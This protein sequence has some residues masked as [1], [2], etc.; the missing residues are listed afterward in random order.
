[1]KKQLCLVLALIVSVS[2]YGQY[3]LVGGKVV[4]KNSRDWTVFREQIEV[5]GFS[6]QGLRCRTFAEQDVT[7]GTI[8]LPGSRGPHP[9]TIPNI[10]RSRT[11]GETFV[12]INYPGSG[13]FRAGDTIRTPI[14]AMR[15]SSPVVNSGADRIVSQGYS[16]YDYGVDYV[17]PQRQLT[18]EETA[19]AAVQAVK[20]NSNKVAAKLKF[21]EEQ[22]DNGKAL[23]QYRMG[24]RYLKGDGVT[25]DLA[26]AEE[27]F[28]KSAAQGNEDAAA[29]LR[30]LSEP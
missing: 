7:V 8:V 28:F 25:N 21:E 10:Q 19:A 12:L 4:M 27:Y 14:A 2:A 5:I 6:G 22:A 23:Y 24:V 13:G 29:Q 30:K 11:Y 17:P 16:F 1:M 18:P 20:E 15:V 26:K 3:K 9:Q